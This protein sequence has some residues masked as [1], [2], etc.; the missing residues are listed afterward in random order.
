MIEDDGPL[1]LAGLVVPLAGAVEATEDPFEPY[2]LVDPGGAPVLPVTVFLA[3]LQACGRS[4]LTQRSYSMALL[5][6]FRFL[7]AAGV[8]WDQATRVEARDFVRWV[9][10]AGKPARRHWRGGDDAAGVRPGIPVPN[11]VTGKPPPGPQYATATVAHGETVARTFYDFHLQGGTGPLVNPFPLARAGRAHVHHNPMDGFGGQRAGLFR[12]RVAQRMPR[13]IPDR[14]FD[15]LFA[16]LGSHRDRALLAFWISTGA[17]ASE[18]LGVLAGIDPGQQL[19]TV[20][21]KGARESSSC[22]PRPTHSCGCVF[23][24]RRCPAWCRRVGRSGV[25]DA[26]A[27]FRVLSYPAARAMFGRANQ[28]LGANWTLHDLR[29]SASYRLARDPAVR[30]T[31][32]QWILGHAHLSTTELYLKKPSGIA[33]AGR[34]CAGRL[35]SGVPQ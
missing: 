20:I 17:R 21:R 34:V 6:W 29:H 31:D 9:Q 5:R 10:V 23:T 32:V 12:P 11:P 7:W 13:Q 25:V 4:A 3:D 8:P 15:E 30:L 28:V 18:L 24:S 35:V 14:R 26:A 33:S 19:V 1:G 16:A 22:P 2:R 27:A